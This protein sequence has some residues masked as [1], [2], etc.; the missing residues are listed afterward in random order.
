MVAPSSLLDLPTVRLKP[1]AD[2][3]KI[4]HGSPWVFAS[5]SEELV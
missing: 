3:R 1:K 2:A 4:R 5:R